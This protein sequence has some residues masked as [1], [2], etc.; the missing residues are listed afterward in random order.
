MIREAEDA[1]WAALQRD[2]AEAISITELIAVHE[3]MNDASRA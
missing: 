2:E 1:A 3:R